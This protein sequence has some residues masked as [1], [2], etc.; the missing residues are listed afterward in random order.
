MD[1]C[2]KNRI[3]RNR[4][5]L[6][7]KKN[8]IEINTTKINEFIKSLPFKL[9]EDQTQAIREIVFDMKKEKLMY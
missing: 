6:L 1:F 5:A 7:S 8:D 4:N 2:L 3:V 9:T